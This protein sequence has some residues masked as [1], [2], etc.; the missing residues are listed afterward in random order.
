MATWQRS[1]FLHKVSDLKPTDLAETVFALGQNLPGKAGWLFYRKLKRRF[2]DR[3]AQVFN[4]MVADLGP[5]DIAIDL[6]ANVG[7][8]TVQFA[9]TGAQVHAFEP[10]PETFVHLTAAL[11]GYEN[12]H[13]H[14]AAVGKVDGTV[15][16]Y[17]PPSWQDESRR[18]SASKANTIVTNERSA[19]F[20][21]GADVQL[22]DFARFLN[23]LPKP[24]KLI[25]VDI[26]GA[27]WDMLDAVEDRAADRFEAMFVETHE[28]FDLS[29]LPM[30]KARQAH[31]AATDRPYV[32]LYWK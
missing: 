18:R 28:R 13:L 26:E 7:E 6:G 29:I 30:L 22:I 17:R 11:A 25:K 15:T 32:N 1:V 20:N 23:E 5:D 2:S 9:A 27:E 16:L 14:N 4:R 21:A 24:A 10:D 12:V 3:S 8:I 19:G 31:Y